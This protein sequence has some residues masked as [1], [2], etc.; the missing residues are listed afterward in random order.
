MLYWHT[1]RAGTGPAQKRRELSIPQNKRESLIYTVMMCFVMVLW[2]SIYNVSLQQGGFGLDAV[3][4]GWLGFPL[5]YVFA[6]C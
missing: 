5:A 6:M 1:H 3:A 2:M 4:A